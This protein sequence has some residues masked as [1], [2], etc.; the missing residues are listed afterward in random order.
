MRSK[1]SISAD[2]AEA[3][4]RAASHPATARSA[5]AL[6]GSARSTQPPGPSPT[7]REAADA[8]DLIEQCLANAPGAWEAFFRQYQGLIHSTVRRYHLPEEDAKEAFQTSM[9]AIYRQLSNL[10]DRTRLHTWIVS[11]ACRQSID[12]IR[13]RTR[14]VGLDE[15][16]PHLPKG[17]LAARAEPLPDREIGLLEDAQRARE[18]LAAASERCRKLLTNLFLQDPPDDYKTV[19]ER[20]GIQVSSVGALR[21]RC[22]EAMRRFFEARGWTA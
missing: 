4:H 3:A 13:E 2:S 18:A 1:P 5:A 11:I 8:E 20:E 7:V 12:R 6:S 15:T 19:A 22:L 9:V 16:D 10:R 14:F 17:S 21:G